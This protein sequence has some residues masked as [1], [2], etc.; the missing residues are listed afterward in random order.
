MSASDEKQPGYAAVVEDKESVKG[1]LWIKRLNG[2]EV[3]LEVA[4]NKP[5]PIQ[6]FN[7][8][9]NVCVLES[10][11]STS[12][13]RLSNLMGECDNQATR[14]KV[15]DDFKNSLTEVEFSLATAKSNMDKAV[16]DSDATAIGKAVLEQ[17]RLQEHYNM[18]KAKSKL[19]YTRS[20]R[21]EQVDIEESQVQSVMFGAERFIL[22]W[23]PD[24]KVEVV[25]SSQTSECDLQARDTSTYSVFTAKKMV[26]NSLV[27]DD[28]VFL[29]SALEK[30]RISISRWYRND[31][32][33]DI[34]LVSR[35]SDT[36]PLYLRFK[37]CLGEVNVVTAVSD[38]N[39]S[40]KGIQ[41][42]KKILSVTMKLSWLQNHAL[43]NAEPAS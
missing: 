9:L 6:C 41:G 19:T 24:R 35:A 33:A 2:E 14:Q 1:V 21:W 5:N 37:F 13:L 20:F 26:S 38:P 36:F 28:L 3:F 25:T 16:H 22:Q 43:F 39:S 12:K 34:L 4:Q 42:Q 30:S 18:L 11:N 31:G 10:S 27:A 7:L 23:I 15:V 32:Y 8:K 17:K 29:H 40:C